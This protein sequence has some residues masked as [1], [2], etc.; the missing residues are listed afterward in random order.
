MMKKTSYIKAI[1]DGVIQG[2]C[3]TKLLL[4]ITFSQFASEAPIQTYVV[5]ACILALFTATIYFFLI[6]KERSNKNLLTLSAI[7]FL[8]FAISSPILFALPFSILP[9]REIG[10]TE[11]IFL[12]LVLAFFFITA[13]VIR[14]GV[15]VG[16]L[17][18]NKNKA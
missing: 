17:V 15:L 8:S 7:S 6:H 11:G 9:Q 18:K 1:T 14:L 3:G 2:F 12:M 13:V 5:I 16:V 10:D 4:G